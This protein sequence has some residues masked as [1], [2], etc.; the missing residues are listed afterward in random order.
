MLSQRSRR[1]ETRFIYGT[2]GKN[3]LQ[4]GEQDW[5]LHCP[6]VGPTLDRPRALD[7]S[8]RSSPGDD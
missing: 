3:A 5:K 1:D 2:L 7:A 8:E 6:L 4:R